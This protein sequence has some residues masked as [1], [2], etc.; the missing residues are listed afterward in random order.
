ML[1][2]AIEVALA[3]LISGLLYLGF[4]TDSI[5]A[6]LMS[7]VIIIVIRAALVAVLALMALKITYPHLY[8]PVSE[9]V[10]SL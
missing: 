8:Q 6:A 3:L 10:P 7:T 9:V 5:D 1:P 2:L 4:C